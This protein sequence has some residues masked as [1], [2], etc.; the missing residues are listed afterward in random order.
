MTPDYGIIRETRTAAGLSKL[1]LGSLQQIGESGDF[2]HLPLLLLASGKER[3]L[4]VIFALHTKKQTG[5]YPSMDTMKGYRHSITHSITTLL[6]EVTKP[7]VFGANWIATA[8]A[9]A[10]DHAFLTQNQPYR[11]MVG[12]LSHFGQ[13]GRYADLDLVAGAPQTEQHPEEQWKRME[14]EFTFLDELSLDAADGGRRSR[15]KINSEVVSILER[16]FRAL[17]RWFTL[18][19][20]APEA[21]RYSNSL[22]PFYNLQDHQLGRIDIQSSQ[23]MVEAR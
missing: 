18:G 4:K 14:L 10:E 12:I 11:E 9:G 3:L 16:S 2:Y 22:S 13:H 1:G 17:A 20:G 19:G 15:E 6:D 21:K 7:A 8:K 5:S 23:I